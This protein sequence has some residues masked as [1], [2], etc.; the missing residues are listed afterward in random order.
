MLAATTPCLAPHY[1]RRRF[2]FCKVISE[3]YLSTY[4]KKGKKMAT[5]MAPPRFGEESKREEMAGPT[6][7]PHEH[8]M[9]PNTAGGVDPDQTCVVFSG[10]R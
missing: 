4:S 2:I 7:R 6:R 1:P 9:A 3:K 10:R 5:H 8:N